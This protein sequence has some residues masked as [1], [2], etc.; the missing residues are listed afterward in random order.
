M[1]KLMLCFSIFAMLASM[2]FAQ[3]S[4]SVPEFTILEIKPI[5]PVDQYNRHVYYGWPTVAVDAN[6][7]LF[8]VASGGRDD[9]VC[10]F[11][12]V[13]FIRS[14]NGGENW[15]WPQTA[16]DGPI[17]DRDA[18]IVITPKGTII[19]TTFTS[20]VYVGPL[21]GAKA[22]R[23]A[24]TPNFSETKYHNWLA[25]HERV[26]EEERQNALG[27]FAVRSTDNGANWS[28]R[29]DTIVNSPHGPTVLDDGRLLYV[30]RKMFVEPEVNGVAESTDDG[31]TWNW[32]TELPTRE[33]DTPIYY[34]EWHAVQTAS[35]KIIAQARNHSP[36][37]TYETLQCESV[38]GGKTWTTPHSTGVWGYPSHLLRLHDNRLLMTYGHRRDPV[39]NQVR[40]SSDEGRTWSGPIV[41]SDD[42]V[43]GDIG[44]PSTTQLKDGTLI[45]VWYEKVP[46]Y[47][48][49]IIRMA[50]WKLN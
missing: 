42:G 4:E 6:D 7:Q 18:G 47:P 43:S 23:E 19:L 49:C 1:K 35:G 41:I 9:H 39:G 48:K 44:Y 22:N 3:E 16:L 24:G 13:D 26:S 11:G 31:K 50:K 10:P 14:H 21:M 37:N 5:T 15:T 45:T 46:E 20:L 30:G 34:H 25:A 36:E 8:V 33:G 28:E 12:R 27:S 17:D 32:V 2:S 40:I 38:D 29:I